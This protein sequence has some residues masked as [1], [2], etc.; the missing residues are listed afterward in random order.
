MSK[1][2]RKN[3]QK[4]G[5]LIKKRE[6]HRKIRRVSKQ[7]L[8][9]DEEIPDRDQIINPYD[10]CDYISFDYPDDDEVNEHWNRKQ[11]RNYI[12]KVAK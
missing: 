12:K 11:K 2:L 4:S 8:N 1:S 3:I 5:C 10:Y 9:K 6:Y 7:Y